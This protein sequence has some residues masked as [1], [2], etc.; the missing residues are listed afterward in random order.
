[1]II[2]VYGEVVVN[3][4]GS[5]KKKTSPLEDENDDGVRHL[6][7]G[8]VFVVKQVLN[9]KV[10]VTDLEEKRENIFYMRCHV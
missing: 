5:D 3:S 1:M 6:V 10:K 2:K 7:D 9:V 8:K 4:Q